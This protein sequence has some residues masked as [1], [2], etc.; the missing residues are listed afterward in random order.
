MVF[1]E[2]MHANMHQ[3]TTLCL[4]CHSCSILSVFLLLLV[5]LLDLRVRLLFSLRTPLSR[6]PTHPHAPTLQ[7]KRRDSNEKQDTHAR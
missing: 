4:P 6:S 2:M 1:D 7:R 5:D 3:S